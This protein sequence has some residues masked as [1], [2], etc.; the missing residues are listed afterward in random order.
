MLKPRMLLLVA[1]LFL[2]AAAMG[3][4]TASLAS[5]TLGVVEPLDLE[6]PFVFDQPIVPPA[7][8]PII[9][10]DRVSWT[11]PTTMPL[12]DLATQWGVRVDKL[13]SLNPTLATER[14]ADGGQ[15]LLVYDREVDR[16]AQSVGAPNRGRLLGGVPLPEGDHWM[17]RHHRSEIWGSRYT[18]EGLV[19]AMDAYGERFPEGPAIRLG[20]I[21]RRKGGRIAPHVS[22]RTGRDVDIGY[23]IKPDERKDRYWQIANTESFDVERN[24]TFIKALIETGRVQQIFM[25][26]RLQRLIR[27]RAREDLSP[28]RFAEYFRTDE[29]DPQHPPI[30]KHWKGHKNHMH[31]RFGCEPGNGRCRSRSR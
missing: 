31:V 9:D 15:R 8:A 30:I 7:D 21:S 24:W 23:I 27:D 10:L 1:P 4:T 13:V 16:P 22:H 20:D 26:S 14:K 18:V 28:E 6:L 25:S 19:M 29:T 11:V 5:P 12:V 17:V 3:T 2:A